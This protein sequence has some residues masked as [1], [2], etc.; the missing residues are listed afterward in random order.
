MRLCGGS[1]RDR[2]MAV[3]A[4]LACSLKLRGPSPLFEPKRFRARRGITR[5]VRCSLL[6]DEFA[7]ASSSL[8]GFSP[9]RGEE[10]KHKARTE[11][12]V[13]PLESLAR[14]RH[15][16][17]ISIIEARA[18]AIGVRAHKEHGRKS[19]RTSAPKAGRRRWTVGIYH[20]AKN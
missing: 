4:S 13:L 18:R 5:L 11:P 15:R 8:R 17:G 14:H 20:P 10:G 12:L 16:L 9:L 19:S 3:G 1:G 2:E 6:D 7:N